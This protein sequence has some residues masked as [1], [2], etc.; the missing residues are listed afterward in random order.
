MKGRVLGPCLSFAEKF[1]PASNPS[2]EHDRKATS[3]WSAAAGRRFVMLSVAANLTG[4]RIHSATLFRV[5][6]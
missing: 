2:D 1:S 6:N 3:L 4:S 5:K